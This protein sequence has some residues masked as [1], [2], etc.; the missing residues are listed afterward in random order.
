[1]KAKVWD[2][3]TRGFKWMTLP[4]PLW[5]G[6]QVISTGVSL[7]G[8]YRGEKTGRKVVE[9]YSYWVNPRNNQVE[10]NFFME[11]EDSKW[12]IYCDYAGIDPQVEAEE[13]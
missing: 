10:G 4:K 1:M 6:R 11:C 2:A 9:T 5:V 3:E 8:L 7:V 12:V 13:L